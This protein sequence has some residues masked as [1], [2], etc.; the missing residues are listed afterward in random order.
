MKLFGN[1]GNILQINKSFASK[2]FNLKGFIINPK[3]GHI[4]SGK[5]ISMGMGP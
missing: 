1:L 2:I 3:L 5:K 4:V